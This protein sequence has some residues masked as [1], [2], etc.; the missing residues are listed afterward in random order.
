MNVMEQLAPGR[1]RTAPP[2]SRRGARPRTVDPKRAGARSR[3]RG[4]TARRSTPKAQGGTLIL[5]V[6]LLAVLCLTGVVMILSASSILSLHQFGSPWHFFMRQIMWLALGAVGFAVALRVDHTAWRRMAPVAM[7]VSIGLLFAVLVPGIGI[8]SSGAA[9]WLGTSSLQIQPSEIAK[10]ALVVFAADILDRRSNSRDWKYQALPVLAVLGVLVLLVMAQPDMGTTMVLVCIVS[11]MLFTAGIPA[12]V[13]A[14]VMGLIGGFGLLLAVA[15][16]YRWR[17]MTA[18]MHPFK[19]AS[20]SGYQSVQALLALSH[21]HVLGDGLGSSIASYGYLPNAQTDFIFA[22]L[23]EETGLVGGLVLSGLFAVLGVVG[24]RLAC[25]ARTRYAAL[26]AAGITSWI[27]G[28]AVIN[29]GAV[30]GLLPVTG[31]PLPFVSFGGSSLVINL[32]AMGMLANI[33]RQR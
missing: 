27:V 18:F 33:A 22:V 30:V 12:R 14:G 28:Q 24:V 13:M 32:F 9:R 16:P 31:V 3:A 8:R 7:Y 21:G 17:R 10:L 2:G 25:N 6:S 26:L 20:N 15:A 29:I 23:G 11:A 5:L 19:D 4:Q 1:A